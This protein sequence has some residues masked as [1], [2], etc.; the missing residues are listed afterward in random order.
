MGGVLQKEGFGR[1]RGYR[2]ILSVLVCSFS[3]PTSPPWHD[4]CVLVALDTGS[5]LLPLS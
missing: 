2:T 3:S 1:A 4:L 5:W